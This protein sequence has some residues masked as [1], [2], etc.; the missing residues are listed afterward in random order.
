MGQVAA[1]S[2]AEGDR[3]R[4]VTDWLRFILVVNV[5]V[6]DDLAREIVLSFNTTRDLIRYRLRWILRDKLVLM[7]RGR[8]R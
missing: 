3:V 6:L 7:W 2:A 1:V 5:I 8:K 4:R